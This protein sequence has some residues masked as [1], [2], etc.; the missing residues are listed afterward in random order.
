MEK[1]NLPCRVNIEDIPV[2]KTVEDY[3]EDTL[4]VWKDHEPIDCGSDWDE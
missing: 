2:G 1:E 4:F 3:P